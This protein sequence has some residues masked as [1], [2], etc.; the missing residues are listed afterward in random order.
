MEHVKNHYKKII[1]CDIC[2]K[3]ICCTCLN[4]NNKLF[5]VLN[6]AKINSTALLVACQKCRTSAFKVMKNEINKKTTMLENNSKFEDMVQRFEKVEI[7][8]KKLEGLELLN[9]SIQ[10]APEKLKTTYADIANNGN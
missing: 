10:Q 7:N 5:N 9:K 8:M 6:E 1:C 2:N 4:V 3:S